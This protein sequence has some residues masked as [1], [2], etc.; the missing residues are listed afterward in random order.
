MPHALRPSLPF[1]AFV[2]SLLLSLVVAPAIAQEAPVAATLA[3]VRARLATAPPAELQELLEVI[4]RL[5]P[6]AGDALPDVRALLPRT[7]LDS[8]SLLNTLAELAPWHPLQ[9]ADIAKVAN[10]AMMVRVRLRQNCGEPRAEDLL[11][12]QRWRCRAAFPRDLDVATLITVARG[13]DA[14]RRELAIECL[15]QRGALAEAALPVLRELL[16]GP[17]PRLLLTEKRVPLHRKAAAAILSIAPH[18]EAAAIARD[19]LANRR[20]PPA[21]EPP[22]VPVRLQERIDALVAD[23]AD[24]AR[25]TAAIANLTALGEPACAP[26]ARLLATP[27]D[28]PT[29]TAALVVLRDLGAGGA[30][31]VAPLLIALTTLP[32]QHSVAIV[33]TLNATVSW[34]GDVAPTISCVGNLRAYRI[35][36][37]PTVG[38]IDAEWATRMSRAVVRF[39]A[40]QRVSRELLVAEFA[41]PL[42]DR[43]VEVRERALELVAE[44]GAAARPLLPVLAAMLTEAPIPQHTFDWFAEP[45]RSITI[46]RSEHVHRAAARAIL[47]IAAAGDPLRV[48][49]DDVLAGPEPK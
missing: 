2:P 19:V 46:D 15:G 33:E 49:A 4:T 7:K 27:A 41:L 8:A 22:T 26:V 40:I 10:E 18:H 30:A 6:A 45:V 9:P 25:R 1:H 35:L 14:F 16:D 36:G 31:A 23:L 21:A 32:V 24:P 20:A 37:K 44:R 42:A 11:A 34:S 38:A 43:S 12:E 28:A 5:G 3:E 47:A 17:E 48:P 39:M 13:R 29:I